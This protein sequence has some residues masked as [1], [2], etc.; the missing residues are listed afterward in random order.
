MV[1]RFQFE[2]STSVSGQGSIIFWTNGPELK[3]SADGN[4]LVEFGRRRFAIL[5]GSGDQFSSLPPASRGSLQSRDGVVPDPRGQR[6]SR[7]DR[8]R[9]RGSPAAS[10]TSGERQDRDCPDPLEC[11]SLA[12]WWRTSTTNMAQAWKPS[13]DGCGSQPNWFRSKPRLR[14]PE[15][16]PASRFTWKIAIGLDR[17]SLQEIQVSSPENR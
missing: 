14:Q 7:R 16:P 4:R 9:H 12:A 5:P 15:S 6:I 1:E 10:D 2:E 13:C 8:C 11:F 17:G 3:L